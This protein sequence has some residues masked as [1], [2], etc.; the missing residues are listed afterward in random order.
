MNFDAG[1][2]GKI[3]L[4]CLQ[5]CSPLIDEDKNRNKQIIEF[6]A[7]DEKCLLRCYRKKFKRDKQLESSSKY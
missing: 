7:L 2:E 5:K 6:E 3:S 4:N 1:G